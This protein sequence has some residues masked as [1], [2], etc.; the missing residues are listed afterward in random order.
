MGLSIS[1]M[2]GLAIGRA[3][4]LEM[5]IAVGFSRFSL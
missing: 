1:G 3:I 5:D 2:M 4:L